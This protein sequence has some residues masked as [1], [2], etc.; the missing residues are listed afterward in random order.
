MGAKQ[1]QFRV[2]QVTQ[3]TGQSSSSYPA[4]PLGV[5]ASTNLLVLDGVGATFSVPVH[6]PTLSVGG[7]NVDPQASSNS[8][9]TH[10]HHTTEM[11]SHQ[12]LTRK[13]RHAHSH[14]TTEMNSIYVAPATTRIT[15]NTISQMHTYQDFLHR[16]EVTKVYKTIR[17]VPNFFHTEFH[18]QSV[19]RTVDWTGVLGKPDFSTLYYPRGSLDTLLA[20]YTTTT[21]LANL[22]AGKQDVHDHNYVTLAHLTENHHSKQSVDNLVGQRVFQGS[23]DSFVASTNTALLGKA[24]ASSLNQY[25]LGT[26][27]DPILAAKVSYSALTPILQ[28]YQQV[29]DSILRFVEADANGHIK[30]RHFESGVAI[31]TWLPTKAITESLQFQI[32]QANLIYSLHVGQHH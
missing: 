28:G 10:H 23:F 1:A 31:H 25:V 12:H 2:K 20:G 8:Y 21:D 26:T 15:R 9:H 30:V 5:E 7:Y 32:T 11:H 18:M 24:N 14:L 29:D 22:L 19:K 16:Q 4:D 3:T 13:H 27:L 6:V 17:T